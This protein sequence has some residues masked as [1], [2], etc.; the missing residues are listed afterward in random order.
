MYRTKLPVTK[1]V[2]PVII[3]IL[4]HIVA[5]TNIIF[6]K[7][8][9]ALPLVRAYIT[10]NL[11][12][13]IYSSPTFFTLCLLGIIIIDF[14]LVFL[15]YQI[16]I[17]GIN[18]IL[19]VNIRTDHTENYPDG[20]YVMQCDGLQIPNPI[21][22][23]LPSHPY[24]YRLLL[25]LNFQEVGY[26]VRHMRYISHAFTCKIPLHD[27]LPTELRGFEPKISLCLA[28]HLL[29][30]IEDEDKV[31]LVYHINFHPAVQPN[32]VTT[33]FTVHANIL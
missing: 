5:L 7:V 16:I 31:S 2:S 4:G 32:P 9:P 23:P 13:T 17:C 28:R 30:A 14:L 8:A 22:S 27:S 24:Q 19:Q 20:F 1:Y 15:S 33:E 29:L 25:V 21:Q 10:P 6:F 3:F 18:H 26:L 11:A 12:R